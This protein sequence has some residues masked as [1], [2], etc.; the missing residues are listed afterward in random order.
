MNLDSQIALPTESAALALFQGHEAH[1][2]SG[3]AA[4]E[5]RSVKPEQSLSI[6][7]TIHTLERIVRMLIPFYGPDCPVAIYDEA[8]PESLGIR[9]TLGAIDGWEPP[10]QSLL[11]VIG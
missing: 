1:K 5:R 11:L 4:F 2:D 9:A 6:H 3:R 8:A 7:L 10:H